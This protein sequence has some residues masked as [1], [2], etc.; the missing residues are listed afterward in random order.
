MGFK[1]KRI[2]FTS[3]DANFP[4]SYPTNPNQQT[5]AQSI[6]KGIAD[7][8]IAMNIGWT[9]DTDHVS[10]TSD[11]VDIPDQGNVST[12]GPWP[13][14][15]L[16]NQTSGCKLFVCYVGGA[17]SIKNFSG[18]DI[19]LETSSAYGLN[20]VIMSMIPGGSSSVFGSPTETTFIPS[21]ATRLFGTATVQYSSVTRQDAG[22][23]Y[24][25]G[26]WATDSCVGICGG[27]S[28]TSVLPNLK[29]PVYLCGKV[30]T[31]IFNPTDVANN[32]NYATLAL[33]NLP[34]SYE[35]GYPMTFGFYPAATSSEQQTA[36]GYTSGLSTSYNFGC[37]SK[38]DG[39]W[40][41]G[42]LSTQNTRI[43]PVNYIP[44]LSRLVYDSTNG[45]TMW[46][47]YDIFVV[48]NNL[49][50][51]GI[52]TKCSY[53]GRLDP[54]LFRCAYGTYGQLFDNGN[55]ICCNEYNLLLGWDPNNDSLAG[56]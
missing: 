36:V 10:S 21:D 28:N 31:D 1:F 54:S 18:N 20:G 34:T 43:L 50:T 48:T 30:I 6:V 52:T 40:I 35:S 51:Y 2:D 16:V 25:W 4:G 32:S 38:A 42:S 39:S 24:S 46:C 15:F 45:D 53:K 44:Y 5:C 22:E 55:F 7:A 8:L 26:I 17:Y 56:T 29:T 11:F 37:I 14:L 19:I 23:H 27:R 9:V 13:G 12:Y 3:G 41:M 49:A 47:P 33:C